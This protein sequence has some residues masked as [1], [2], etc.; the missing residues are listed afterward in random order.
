MTRKTRYA[1]RSFLPKQVRRKQ[2][3]TGVYTNDLELQS[4]NG[5][6]TGE[7]FEAIIPQTKIGNKK[8]GG[9][10]TKSPVGCEAKTGDNNVG[11][12]G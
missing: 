2:E 7:P 5:V 10:N 8:R 9:G 1:P 11:P 12:G 6:D 3:E 4:Q